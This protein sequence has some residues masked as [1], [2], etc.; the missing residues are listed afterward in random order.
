MAFC[1]PIPMSGT[2]K[3]G[4]RRLREAFSLTEPRA[5]KMALQRSSVNCY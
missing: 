5:N 2:V 1:S 3:S 4:E